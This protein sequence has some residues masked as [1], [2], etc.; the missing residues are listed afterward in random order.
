MKKLFL[1]FVFVFSVVSA[2]AQKVIITLSSGCQ[3][4]FAAGEVTGIE[5]EEAYTSTPS[6][7][8]DD[9]TYHNGH[10]YVDLGLPS[11]TKWASCNIGATSKEEAG[12]FY[13]WGETETKT[14]YSLDNY[15]YYA[16]S[17]IV[18][19]GFEITKKGYT[20]YVHESGSLQYGYKGFYDNKTMLEPEDDVAYVKWGGKWRMPTREEQDELRTLCT[21]D[22]T[23]FNEIEGYKVTGPNGKY[24]F[25]PYVKG[26][27]AYSL[28]AHYWSS[29]AYS[30]RPD[31]AYYLFISSSS[32]HWDVNGGRYQG[33]S[34]RAVLSAE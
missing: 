6:D 19:N 25:I 5:F 11:G 26:N 14:S 7:P 12:D 13:A 9:G 3:M 20:K 21:W 22:W 10:E 2:N 8:T 29:S 33:Q 4:T 17:T 32:I 15:K 31:L 27:Y 34:V 16:S 28:G 30:S 18:E 24:I 1:L 23:R